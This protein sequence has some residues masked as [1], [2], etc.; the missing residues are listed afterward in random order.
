MRAARLRLGC[1]H[2]HTGRRDRG[3]CHKR[4]RPA[5]RPSPTLTLV[6]KRNG[7]WLGGGGA[8]GG[9]PTKSQSRNFPNC[10]GKM[11][12]PTSLPRRQA[13][14]LSSTAFALLVSSAGPL[15][16]PAE[17]PAA[18]PE[19]PGLPEA[20]PDPNKRDRGMMNEKVLVPRDYFGVFGV[21][22]PRV[23]VQ[24]DSKQPQW[25]AWGACVDNSR[26]RRV[27]KRSALG[28]AATAAPPHPSMAG[29]G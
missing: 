21:V 6:Q 18:A 29:W 19:P 27:R 12:V 14:S 16:A 9:Q 28:T 3:D 4:S 10:V 15:R 5:R 13:V 24:V 22:P 26:A 7:G 11:R 8:D 1:A 23:L 20:Y 17:A 25:N 2:A